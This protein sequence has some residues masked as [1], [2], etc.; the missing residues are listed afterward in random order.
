MNIHELR[1]ERGDAW[2]EMQNLTLTAE[3]EGRLMTADE[4][5]KWEAHEKRLTAAT[6]NLR[7]LERS[8]ELGRG[9]SGAGIDG[10]MQLVDVRTM[11]TVPALRSSQRL[12]DLPRSKGQPVQAEVN[13]DTIVRALHTGD[14]SKVP[15]EERS[16]S[17]GTPSA[18]GFAVSEPLSDRIIDRARNQ[19]RVLQAGATT[20]PMESNTLKV[21]RVA[22]DPTAAWKV[23]NAAA[24]ASDMTLEQVTFTARTLIAIAKASVE[25]V[26][27]SEVDDTIEQAIGSALALELDR[28]ALRGSG[29]APEPRGVRNQ[30]GVTIDSTTFGANGG[31]PTSYDFISNAVQT[32][33]AA[34]GDPNALI[35][36]PR[37]AGVLDRL[38]DTTN[39]PLRP[40]PSVEELRRLVTAQVPI[41]L[42][43]GTSTD[44]SE[45]YVADWSSLL[46]GVRRSLTVEVSRQATTGGES[47]FDR[48]QIHVRAYL[49]ADV[50]L[51]RPSHFVVVTGV[52]G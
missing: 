18:G 10:E 26:E 44:T 50:Q 11:G 13:L 47:A 9:T 40:P 21:A 22:G 52:R 51:A 28:A 48:L 32:I 23:E 17:I 42:T 27:D 4:V 2:A 20:V 49:R 41:N 30:T 7:V 25:L 39:Q 12:A 33:R 5:K 19:A 35:Y 46:I 31:T 29:T 6:D 45:V 15:V 34:N 36:A 1:Q 8:G 43:T 37:T 24:T 3:A 38:K 16:M 14:W